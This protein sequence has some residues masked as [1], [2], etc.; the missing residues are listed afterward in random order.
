MVVTMSP[1]RVAVPLGM[2]SQVGMTPTTLR[3]RPISATAFMTPKTVEAPDMSYFISSMSAGGLREIPPVSKV[4][5][6]PTK[7]S[8][9]SLALPPLCWST[10]N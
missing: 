2:F 6:L 3:L 7:T 1:G 4:M 5:P 9:A 10:M 8:G